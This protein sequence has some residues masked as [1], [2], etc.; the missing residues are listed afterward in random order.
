LDDG[1]FA[2]GGNSLGA[3]RVAARLAGRDLPA[4]AGQIFSAPTVAELAALLQSAGERSE[5]GIARVPRTPR[6]RTTT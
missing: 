6:S 5:P 3:V 1:F 4:T 2:L